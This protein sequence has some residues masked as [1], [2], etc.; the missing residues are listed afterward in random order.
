[1]L[2]DQGFVL[3]HLGT[4]VLRLETAVIAALAVLKA[5]RGSM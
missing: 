2:R 3:V 5:G 1:L 4:R